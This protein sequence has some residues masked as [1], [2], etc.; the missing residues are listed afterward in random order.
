[1]ETR[2]TGLNLAFVVVRFADFELITTAGHINVKA[3][4]SGDDFFGHS[5]FLLDTGDA[6]PAE[7]LTFAH[8]KRRWMGACVL[9]N[10]MPS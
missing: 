10:E 9:D 3:F 5:G 1:M 8:K 6:R 2:S 4:V 7:L